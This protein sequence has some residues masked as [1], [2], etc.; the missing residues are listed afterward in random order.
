VVE[1]ALVLA[2]DHQVVLAAVE[3]EEASLLELQAP[4]TQVVA[5]VE[6][7]IAVLVVLAVPVL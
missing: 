7:V 3:Q 2:Q 1:V 5:A 6:Q 4:L